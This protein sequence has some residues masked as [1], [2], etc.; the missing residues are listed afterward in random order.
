MFT[1]L[2]NPTHN[3]VFNYNMYDGN[4]NDD[5]VVASNCTSKKV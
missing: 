3:F 4:D 2:Q 5:T 1:Y